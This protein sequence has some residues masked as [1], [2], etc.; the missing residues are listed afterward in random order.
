MKKKFS[1]MLALALAVTMFASLLVSYAA[2]PIVY[3]FTAKGFVCQDENGV[4]DNAQFFGKAKRFAYEYVNGVSKLIY[5]GEDGANNPYITNPNTKIDASVYKFVK[6]AYWTKVSAATSINFYFDNG[7]GIVA[8]NNKEAAITADGTWQYAVID[9]SDVAAWTGTI[10][11]I[12]YDFLYGGTL[13]AGD[14]VYCGY[15]ALFDSKATADG[16][17]VALPDMA[18][19][20]ADPDS[21]SKPGFTLD[22]TKYELSDGFSIK[23]T[24]RNAPAAD[25][26]FG[27]YPA[28]V[29]EPITAAQTIGTWCYADATKEIPAE[30]IKE[31][32]ITLTEAICDDLSKL[33]VGDYKIIMFK[34]GSEADTYT[35]L[36]TKTFSFIE[37]GSPADPEPVPST[38][39]LGTAA[40][41]MAV[42]AAAVCLRR[43]AEV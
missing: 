5:T 32:T 43:K 8:G 36:D 38:G 39:D 14:Y 25:T 18:A 13:E 20:E 16:Y 12:R 11:Q 7:S 30:L 29:T 22:N 28:S 40:V 34:G 1:L 6:I 41:S 31:G 2:D 26:W 33:S 9:M 27:I 23:L 42:G 19:Y 21:A 24:F 10:Q 15:I 4:K 37:P 3:D 35:V 17:T